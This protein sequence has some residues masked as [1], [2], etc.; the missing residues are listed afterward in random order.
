MSLTPSSVPLVDLT[1][2]YTQVGP[3]VDA[4]IAQVLRSADHI[5]GAEVTCF[6]TEFASFCGAKHAIGVDSG[7]SALELALRAY[8]IGSGDQVITAANTYM[9]TP[10]AISY[11]G[12][13]PV[14]VDADPETLL[15]DVAAIEQAITRRTRAIV[16]VHLY[17][18]PAEMDEIMEIARRHSLVVIEDAS[19]APGARYHGKRVGSLGHAAAFA[20]YPDG[21]LGAYGDGGAIVTNDDRVAETLRMM[22]N[23]GQRAEHLHE[24]KGY[25]RRL[26]TLQAAAL[27]VKL[28]FLERWNEARQ[29]HA[30]QY[31]RT[32]RD[33]VLQLPVQASRVD[34]VWHRYVVRLTDRKELQNRLERAGSTTGIHYPI[35]VHMQPAFHHL[36]YEPGDF[37]V[38]ERLA[39]QVL[40]LPMYPEMSSETVERIGLLVRPRSTSS[41]EFVAAP[42]AA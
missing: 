7:T 20:F 30:K 38:A 36:G 6:E 11:T 17:G 13:V 42:A 8:G 23:L 2:Q 39:Q 1:A 24:I 28:K 32:L 18:H 26:D 40:S 9:T 21:N 14:L 29:K 16:P 10:L 22:R 34:P 33:T 12:A 35:P 4:A 41:I 5:L 27:S 37:P 25:S 3:E 31:E 15:I 19:H